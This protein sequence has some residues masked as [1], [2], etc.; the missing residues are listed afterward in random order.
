MNIRKWKKEGRTD[1]AWALGP[2]SYLKEALRIFEDQMKKNV[3][4]YIGKDKQPF[5]RVDYR[6]ELNET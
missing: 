3:V 4:Q 1:D 2:N 6:L 5:S